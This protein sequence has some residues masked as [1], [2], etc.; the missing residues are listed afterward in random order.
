LWA[1]NFSQ[2]AIIL[3]LVNIKLGVSVPVPKNNI[4]H[5]NISLVA[6]S[7]RKDEKSV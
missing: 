6:A 4:T 7:H 3:N 2:N 5:Y 1:L